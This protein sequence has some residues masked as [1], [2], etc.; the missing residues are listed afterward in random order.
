MT[1]HEP[2]GPEPVT[3]DTVEVRPTGRGLTGHVLSMR[4]PSVRFLIA[5][6]RGEAGD[7]EYWEEILDA[8]TAHDLDRDPGRLTAAQVNAIGL[9]WL[10]AMTEAALPPAT[11]TD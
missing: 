6:R 1:E 11:G 7:P 8:I 5:Q 9:A 10:E 3:F 4:R 2:D